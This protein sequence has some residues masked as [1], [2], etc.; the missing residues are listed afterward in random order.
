MR[1]NR[2]HGSEGG[3][4]AMENSPTPIKHPSTPKLTTENTESADTNNTPTSR[5]LDLSTII[6]TSAC[7]L[8]IFHYLIH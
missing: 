2:L 6:S 4:P 5:P 7:L 8:L 1:E 3:E